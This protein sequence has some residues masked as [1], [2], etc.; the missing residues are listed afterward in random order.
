M[1]AAIYQGG[2]RPI[3][4]E[5]VADPE[6]LR[7]ELLVE[8]G[9]CGVCGSDVSM[10]SGTPFDY[11]AGK[12]FGHEFAGTVL[13]VGRD[14]EGFRTGDRVACMP[15][16]PCGQCEPCREGRLLFCTRDRG[17]ATGFSEYVAVPANAAVRLPQTLS[18]ADGAMVEPMACGLR[19]LRSAGMTAGQRVLVLGAGSMAMAIVWWA[20]RL[21]A[22]SVVVASRSS[23]RRDTCMLFGAD[24]VH[25]LTD[26]DP[27]ELG[28]ELGGAPH[29]VAECVGKEGML[30]LAVRH[31][32]LGGTV[33][34]MGMCMRPEPVL[35][36][37]LTMKEV[38]LTFPLA[39]SPEEFEETARAFDATGFHPDQMVSEVLALERLNSV[40]AGMR[41]G[42]QG[43]KVHIDPRITP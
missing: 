2:G 11:E 6:L 26:D 22:A 13:D 32:R 16:S 37:G 5:T 25:S 21:G 15:V 29:I 38:K 10:T 30:N 42:S 41:S 33:I 19:A 28:I 36:I 12:C 3:T 8:V 7:D 23:R 34:G 43:L 14:A 35:P 24:A 39:Y 18:L 17:L 27:A 20:R 31:V 9:R 1:R 40:L 4:I